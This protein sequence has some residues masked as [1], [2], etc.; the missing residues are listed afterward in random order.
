M[1]F[2]PQGLQVPDDSFYNSSPDVVAEKLLGKILLRRFPDGSFLSGRIC[3]TEAYSPEDPASHSY[4][5]IT[6]RNAP[7]FGPPGRAYVYLIYGI[8]HCLNV[9]TGPEGEGSAVLIRGI[10][11]LE[12]LDLIRKRRGSGLKDS[13]LCN[14]PGKICQALDLDRTWNH[15]PFRLAPLQILSD[16]LPVHP[17]CIVQTPRIGITLNA[18]ALRRFL[19]VP[20]N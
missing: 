1:H 7:M 6:E 3:E 8:H 5:G 2:L 19:W 11:P 18:A 17:G 9:V 4:T 10:I 12:G 13:Q 20:E 15:H 16:S 14:G